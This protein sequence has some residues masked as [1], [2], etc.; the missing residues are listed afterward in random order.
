MDQGER[1]EQASTASRLRDLDKRY[2]RF[3]KRK[4]VT[5]THRFM[6]LTFRE[7]VKCCCPFHNVE[8]IFTS[9]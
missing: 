4:V 6:I 8:F 2:F 5:I 7:D 3:Y 1:Q 9:N